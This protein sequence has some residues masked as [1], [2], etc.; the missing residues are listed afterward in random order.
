[1]DRRARTA[2][3]NCAVSLLNV[4]AERSKLEQIWKYTVHL[5]QTV[6]RFGPL[7]AVEDLGRSV[8]FG[9]WREAHLPRTNRVF[10]D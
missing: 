6:F 10:C 4:S 1:M 9:S 2:L 5:R 3:R 7:P 8:S